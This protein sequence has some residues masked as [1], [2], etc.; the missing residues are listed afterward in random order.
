MARSNSGSGDIRRVSVVRQIGCGMRRVLLTT[1]WVLLVLGATGR[2]RDSAG[3][4]A[5][6]EVESSPA[7][8]G[9]QG[10]GQEGA[11]GATPEQVRRP[12]WGY[13]TA[14]DARAGGTQ[15]YAFVSERNDPYGRVYVQCSGDRRLHVFV[16]T[17]YLGR[18]VIR[19][20][21]QYQIDKRPR[22][23]LE[24]VLSQDARGVIIAEGR[25][26]FLA[27]VRSG[28]RLSVTTQRDDGFSVRLGFS[29]DGSDRAIGL[30]LKACD[31]DAR[32][33]STAG[34][35][36]AETAERAARKAADRAA[37]RAAEAAAR[38][39]EEAEREAA[40]RAAEQAELKAQ[41]QRDLDQPKEESEFQGLY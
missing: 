21:L 20:P 33:D 29:L 15:H 19:P 34:D 26:A 12:D 3:Q 30:V 17:E 39:A 31:Y 8:A 37:D 6:G 1:I 23:S 9:E 36:A 11:P 35:R 2:V 5:A 10:A 38:V 41:I 14:R 22:T 25:S 27:A 40:T 7:A 28:R 16:T 13:M 18:A 24:G 32:S 4:E